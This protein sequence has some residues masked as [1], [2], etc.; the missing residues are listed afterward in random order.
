MDIDVRNGESSYPFHCKHE[1]KN[2]AKC[3]AKEYLQR[4]RCLGY[5]VKNNDKDLEDY[6]EDILTFYQCELGYCKAKC[7]HEIP[8]S[9]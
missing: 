7:W 2:T 4:L 6:Q 3:L 9:L 5:D 8:R 1:H